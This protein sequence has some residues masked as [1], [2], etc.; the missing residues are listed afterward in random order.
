MGRKKDTTQYKS[1][2]T[3]NTGQEGLFRYSSVVK[4]RREGGKNK[5]R[6]GGKKEGRKGRKEVIRS[7][8]DWE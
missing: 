1:T 3:R 4:G 5:G 8:I 6:E 7:P 2:D